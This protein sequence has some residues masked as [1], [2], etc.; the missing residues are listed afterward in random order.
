LSHQ[1]RVNIAVFID[2]D[3]IEIGVRTTL[4]EHF[5]VSVILEALKERGEVVTKIAYADWTRAGEYSRHLTQHAIRLVQR[6][7][8]PGG[9]KNGADINL[10]LDALEMAFT[11][12]HINAYVIVGGDS[13]FLSLVE[14]LKQYNKKVFVIGGRQFTS[15][16]L[17]KNCHEFIAYEN[18]VRSKPSSSRGGR[19]SAPLASAPIAGAFPLVRRAIKILAD[20]EVTP[21][22]GLLKSTLLQLDS[23]FSERSYGASSFLDFAEKLAQAGFVQLKHAG[24]SVM[25]ELNPGFSE[26]TAQAATRPVVE[27]EVAPPIEGTTVDGEAAVA[28]AAPGDGYAP[29]YSG[30]PLPP[31]GDNAD[32][33][34]EA[35]RVLAAATT[36]RWPMYLRNV[37]QIL[38]AAQFDERRY[39]FGGLMDLLKACQ[40]EGLLKVE[41]DRRGGLRVFQ[42]SGLRGGNVAPQAGMPVSMPDVD[43]TTENELEPGN[44]VEPGNQAIPEEPAP[45]IIDVDGEIID[46]PQINV[47]DPVAQMLGRA[48]P[49]R[50]G[51]TRGTTVRGEEPPAPR[52]AAGRGRGT[53]KG[54]G[55]VRKAAG[56]GARRGGGGRKRDPNGDV[57]GNK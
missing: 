25:V 51:K 44:R 39:G 52:A 34:R 12:T 37:K 55:P 36:A 4:G 10:A 11:H 17:Q 42:S 3:N 48:K 22:T 29:Q 30:P 14:K 32:G 27:G 23:T 53:A 6:N 16:I 33:V 49:K 56:G 7:L 1:E 18:L 47:V 35:G 43:P 26:D 9:D 45:V 24:R 40:R 21:Q 2:F 15:V 8:T 19:P 38:R 13:D 20:R 41:R 5:D 28:P 46:E 57:D 50:G 31:L 54:R